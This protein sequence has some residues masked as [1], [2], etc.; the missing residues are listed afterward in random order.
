M[1]KIILFICLFLSVTLSAQK[2]DSTVIPT[3]QQVDTTKELYVDYTVVLFESNDSIDLSGV[4]VMSDVVEPLVVFY[5]N[6]DNFETKNLCVLGLHEGESI[7]ERYKFSKEFADYLVE[8][9]KS[10]YPN[11]KVIPVYSKR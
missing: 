7:I 3:C 5:V 10:T 4:V 9:H 2:P 8:I 6:P 1:K 11:I